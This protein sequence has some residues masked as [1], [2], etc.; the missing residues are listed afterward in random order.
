MPW[1]VLPAIGTV[2][3]IIVGFKNTTLDVV[4]W[5]NMNFCSAA[6]NRNKIDI[7]YGGL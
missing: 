6:V 5:H 3:G 2:G 7:F 1:N 4:S